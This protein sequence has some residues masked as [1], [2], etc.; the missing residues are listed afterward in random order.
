MVIYLE[1][2]FVT[3]YAQAV[4][5]DIDLWEGQMKYKNLGGNGVLGEDLKLDADLVGAFAKDVQVSCTRVRCMRS[6]LTCSGYTV[7]VS[8][9]S[10]MF[11]VEA[12]LACFGIRRN[13]LLDL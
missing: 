3:R 1:S 13:F 12:S 10:L 4:N 7:T 8:W 5:P 6:Q 2:A 9:S 11:T